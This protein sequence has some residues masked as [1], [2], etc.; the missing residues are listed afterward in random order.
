MHD[1]Q[2]F[3]IA[4]GELTKTNIGNLDLDATRKEPG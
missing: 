3:P 1:H 4:A 2:Q